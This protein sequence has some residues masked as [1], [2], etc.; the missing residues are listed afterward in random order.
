ML[1]YEAA[2]T[3]YDNP[4]IKKNNENQVRIK[5]SKYAIKE[6]KI[7]SIDVNEAT[8]AITRL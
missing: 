1:K 3:R 2:D 4:I 5:Q 8:S 7:I 6:T